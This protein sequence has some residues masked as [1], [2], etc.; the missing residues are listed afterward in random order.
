[1]PEAFASKKFSPRVTQ[2]GNTASRPRHAVAAE[3]QLGLWLLSTGL[4]VL[5]A[6]QPGCRYKRPGLKTALKGRSPLT[7]RW[8]YPGLKPARN[9]LS[10]GSKRI[11]KP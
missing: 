10:P 7:M 11:Q 8:S 5:G 2:T 1:M 3:E 9:R 6:G 4:L